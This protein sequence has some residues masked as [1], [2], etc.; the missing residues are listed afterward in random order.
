MFHVKQFLHPSLI[1][2]VPRETIP[3]FLFNSDVSR[4]T[5]Y[6][7]SFFV[8]HK[9]STLSFYHSWEREETHI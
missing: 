8:N 4:E 9:S 6:F 5:I 7:P 3:T 2:D 1:P